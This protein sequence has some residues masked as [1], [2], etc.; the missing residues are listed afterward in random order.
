MD[1]DVNGGD[2]A[3]EF[4]KVIP[5]RHQIQHYHGNNV[6]VLFFVSAIVLVV[7]QSTGADLPLSTSGAIISA[8]VLVVAA[9]ITNPSQPTIHW[10]NALISVAGTFIFGISAV[11]HYREGT[12][13]LNPS[14]IYI[15][16]L[17]LLS[18]TALYFTVRTIRGFRLRS[19]LT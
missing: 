17:S 13:A 16:A 15:E 10:F 3:D 9:G 18:L 12:N 5:Q 4:D 19:N 6:R 14:F 11:D 1:F 2:S 8:V 7:A